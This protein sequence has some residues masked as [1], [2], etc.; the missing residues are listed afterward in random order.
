MNYK[1]IYTPCEKNIEQLQKWLILGRF[2]RY[3]A[4]DLKKG[5]EDGVLVI[6]TFKEDAIGYLLYY[7]E[8]PL[9]I[10][11]RGTEIHP[12][13][14]HRGAGTLLVKNCIAKFEQEGIS[15]VYLKSVYNSES[16]WYKMGFNDRFIP[17]GM[18][19]TVHDHIFL[20]LF[21]K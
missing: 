4:G 21:L 9:N 20:R 18:E 13:F 17:I 15:V 5:A 3:F 2:Q 6:I 12:N 1:V 8:S 16:F 14:Q 10:Y 11:I 19:N 7:E